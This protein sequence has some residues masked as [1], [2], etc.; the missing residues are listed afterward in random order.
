MATTEA[1]LKA[2]E[3]FSGENAG[4]KEH[5]GTIGLLARV[6]A[7]VERGKGGAI[8]SP[9]RR[10][11]AGAAQRN[12]PAESQHSSGDG[13]VRSNEPGSAGKADPNPDVWG[14]DGRDDRL[15]GASGVQSKG[16]TATVASAPAAASGVQD[17]RRMAAEKEMSRPDTKFKPITKSGDGNKESNLRGDPEPKSGRIGDVPPLKGSPSDAG[18]QKTTPEAKP[19]FIGESLQGDGWGKAA[20]EAKKRLAAKK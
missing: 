10:E 11:A 5:E 13:Q 6:K 17:I 8:D 1:L 4:K 3:G 2:I 19:P 9:G 7:D 14:S 18:T 20:A 15:T 12:S 16:N